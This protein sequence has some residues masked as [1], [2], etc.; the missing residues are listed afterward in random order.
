MKVLV[1]EDQSDILELIGDYLEM[2][3]YV[4]ILSNDGKIAINNYYKNDD[5]LL[6]ILDVN[7]PNK[8][9]YEVAK[10]IR[11]SSQIPILF[12]SAMAQEEDQ[13]KG[14]MVGGDDYM[15]K[16]FS[17]NILMAKVKALVKSKKKQDLYTKGILKVDKSSHLVM[18]NEERISLSPKEYEL[19]EHFII[20]EGI[21]VTRETLLDEIW[22]Y[23]FEGD[24][25]TVDTHVKRLRAKL[26]VAGEYIRT[27]RGYGYMFKVG[28]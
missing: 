16:P 11:K 20:N 9:G 26:N 1:A 18:V 4:P 12:L 15:T 13:L 28:E 6:A 25:R 7:M 24:L 22:G 8:D 21:L 2:E 14:F 27:V 5:I 10:E 23:D 17:I 3:G 19:M